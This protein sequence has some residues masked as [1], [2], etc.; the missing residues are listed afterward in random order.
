VRASPEVVL[1]GITKQFGAVTALAHVDLHLTRGRIHALLGENGAGKSTLMAVLFGLARPDEGSLRVDGTD[2]VFRSPRDAIAAGIGMVQQHFAHVAAFTVAENVALG[3]QGRYDPA[4]AAEQVRAAAATAGLALDAAARVGDLSIEAQQ[5]VE[6]VRALARGARLLILDEPTAVLAPAEATA[7]LAWLRRFADEGGTVAL[8]THKVREALEVADDIT[9][10]RAG[11]CVT[12]GP[13][14][15]FTPATLTAAMFPE[16]AQL[17]DTRAPVAPT[18]RESRVV[19][20]VRGLSL[21]GPRGEPRIS[22]ATFTIEAGEIVG[23]AGVEGAGHAELL[24]A[25][26][27]VQTP[28]AGTVELP[29]EVSFVPADRHRDALVLDFPLYENLALHHAGQRSGVVDWQDVR[30]RTREV[31]HAF[32]VRAGSERSRANTLSGGNQ[33]RFILGRELELRPQLLVAENPTR[34]LD[35]RATHAIQS[36]LREAAASGAAVVLYSSDLDEVLALA[37]R[38]LV[39]HRGVVREVPHDRDAVARAMVGD[40]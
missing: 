12:S 15:T 10:L 37:G 29:H 14:S 33:Q 3:G 32:D 34:G 31:L 19:A 38:I 24:R 28:S 23:V 1:S 36:R 21:R 18:V 40:W 13:A 27:G 35:L 9:V 5:R 26:A 20:S 4:A 16:A 11:R 2:R 30:R 8:V 22:D 25:L 39:V 7:L 6:I 17:P